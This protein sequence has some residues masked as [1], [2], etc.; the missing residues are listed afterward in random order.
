MGDCMA[1]MTLAIPSI[2][3]K[4]MNSHSE[5]RWSA[6]ARQ[7]FEKKLNELEVLDK[8]LSKSKLTEE[9]SEKIGQEIKSQIRKRFEKR[10]T[11]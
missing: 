10:F 1:N 5:I 9:D 8:L 4:R 6:V 7:A 11:S 3:H 2:I